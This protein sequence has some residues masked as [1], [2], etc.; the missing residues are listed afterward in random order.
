[1]NNKYINYLADLEQINSFSLIVMHDKEKIYTHGQNKKFA[2]GSMSKA[3][4]SY[5]LHTLIKKKLCNWDDLV[6]NWFHLSDS[7]MT[8]KDLVEHQVRYKPHL[9]TQMIDHGYNIKEITNK[10]HDEKEVTEKDF[11]YNNIFYAVVLPK[12]IESVS[13]QSYKKLFEEL[14]NTIGMKDTGFTDDADMGYYMDNNFLVKPANQIR[15]ISNFGFAGG[16]ISTIEDMRLWINFIIDKE[17]F[18]KIDQPNGYGKGW[19]TC[20]KNHIT[21]AHTGSV[22]GYSSSILLIP[23]YKFSICCLCNLTNASFPGRIINFAVKNTFN[24]PYFNINAPLI[25]ELPIETKMFTGEYSNEIFGKFKIIDD[26]II[27]ENVKGDLIYTKPN[28]CTVKWRDGQHVYYENDK[29]IKHED[30]IELHF[31]D[32]YHSPMHCTNNI[33][34]KQHNI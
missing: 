29:I 3:F 32:F 19:W 31:Y 28:E 10:L 13:G 18:L 2:I 9:F 20:D 22:F 27:C 24:I 23:K 30:G 14:L 7:T 12:I 6:S 11:H 15:P 33:T 34:L 26:L 17:D 25:R 5:L 1:M 4:G 8:I 21:R 16:I